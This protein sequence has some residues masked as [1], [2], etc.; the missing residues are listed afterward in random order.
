MFPDLTKKLRFEAP[1]Y[2]TEFSALMQVEGGVLPERF[3][4]DAFASQSTE[5]LHQAIGRFLEDVE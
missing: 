2:L 1:F 4:D 3:A 5:A